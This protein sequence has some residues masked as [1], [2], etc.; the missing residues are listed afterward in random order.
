MFAT[1]FNDYRYSPWYQLHLITFSTLWVEH[2]NHKHFRFWLA[3]CRSTSVGIFELRSL[4][5][6]CSGP[7]LMVLYLLGP[8]H[9]HWGSSFVLFAIA[10]TI[11]RFQLVSLTVSLPRRQKNCPSFIRTSRPFT[12][13]PLHQPIPGPFLTCL[14][15]LVLI[16]PNSSLLNCCWRWQSFVINLLT[17]LPLA[18]YYIVESHSAFR[19]LSANW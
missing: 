10:V 11:S 12:H 13:L 7:H 18:I 1:T 17:T 9:L 2:I 19:K 14:T 15:L 3:G 5:V 6:M 16:F 8:R 4:G